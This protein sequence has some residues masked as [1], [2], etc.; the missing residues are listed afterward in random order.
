MDRREDQDDA[1]R[2]VDS[3]GCGGRHPFRLQVGRADTIPPPEIDGEI[4]ADVESV[5]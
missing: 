3:G 1:R 4:M 5:P 2:V